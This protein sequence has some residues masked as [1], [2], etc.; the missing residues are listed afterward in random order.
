MQ[1]STVPEFVR[2]HGSLAIGGKKLVFIFFLLLGGVR[3]GFAT[4]IPSPQLLSG[5]PASCKGTELV[6]VTSHLAHLL[7]FFKPN[8]VQKMTFC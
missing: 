8:H 1:R 2:F 7:R 5:K 3:F 4:Q 6:W